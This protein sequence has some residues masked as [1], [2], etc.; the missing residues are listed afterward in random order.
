MSEVPLYTPN[1]RTPTPRR[2]V[3]RGDTLLE[4]Q[5]RFWMDFG[6]EVQRPG[7]RV[8]RGTSLIRNRPPPQDRHRSLGMVL[9]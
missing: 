2:L 1:P 9:L 8:Y 7:S 4:K 3:P 6:E 5:L